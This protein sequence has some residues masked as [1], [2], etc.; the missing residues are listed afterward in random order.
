M[1]YAGQGLTWAAANCLNV[2][3]DFV[4]GCPRT[5]TSEWWPGWG[6]R[7]SERIIY[8]LESVGYILNVRATRP[9]IQRRSGTSRDVHGAEAIKP[10]AEKLQ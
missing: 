5:T 1:G 9:T 6:L 8:C 3:G 7:L 4:R 10:S 2:P